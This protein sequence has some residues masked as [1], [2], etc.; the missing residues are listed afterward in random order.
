MKKFYSLV[1]VLAA[2]LTFAQGGENFEAQ[3][4]LSLSGTNYDDG[5]L[6]AVQTEG[7]TVNFVHSR[8]Q[9]DYPIDGKG[10]MLRRSNEP[11]SVSFIIPNGVGEFQFQYRKAFTSTAPRTLVVAV[12]GEEVA[13]TEEFG[14]GSGEQTQ[15]YT[16]KVP[17]EVEGQ[18]TITITYPSNLADGNRQLT[19]DNVLWSAKGEV[20]STVN[21]EATKSIQNTVWTNTAVFSTKGNASVE[22]YNVNG[23]LV[24]SFEVNGNKNVNVSDLAAG[25]YYVRSTENGKSITTKVVKK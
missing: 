17:V 19:I 18:V 5:T 12:N 3:T 8:D 11:S 9:G 1:A 4:N 7:V 6:N 23:Q 13:T 21:V 10:I 20:L 15:V 24:K 25:V 2:S 16:L 14:S 22:V